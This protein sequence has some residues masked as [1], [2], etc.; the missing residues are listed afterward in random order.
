MGKARTVKTTKRGR[1]ALQLRKE[2]VRVLGSHELEHVQGG[3]H[4]A[5]R[6]SRYCISGVPER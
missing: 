3:G 1:P 6:N 5:P 2:V 4:W